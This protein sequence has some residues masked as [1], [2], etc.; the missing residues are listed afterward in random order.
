MATFNADKAK[1]LHEPLAFILHDERYELVEISQ[2]VINEVKRIGALLENDEI[3]IDEAYNEILAVCT[4][5]DPSVFEQA[6]IR[7]K[8]GIN[9]WIAENVFSNKGAQAAKNVRGK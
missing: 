9:D 3:D 6:T 1:S 4:G 5:R 8:R 7:E 2:Q